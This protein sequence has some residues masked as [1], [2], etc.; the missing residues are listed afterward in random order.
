M[1]DAVSRAPTSK[2]FNTSL[3]LFL[4][5]DT[6][7][8]LSLLFAIGE[9]VVAML[10]TETP[11]TTFHGTRTNTSLNTVVHAGHRDPPQPSLIDST[12]MTTKET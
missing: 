12:F 2:K 9:K 1:V 11:R 8:P 3:D 7:W 10:N 6:I 4:G 5:K